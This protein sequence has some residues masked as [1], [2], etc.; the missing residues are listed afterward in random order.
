[1]W[2]C[3]C[4]EINIPIK[5]LLTTI[6][7]ID[8]G[9]KNG[10]TFC[11]R[12]PFIKNTHTHI[13][14]LNRRSVLKLSQNIVVDVGPKAK[15]KF[16]Y[17]VRFTVYNLTTMHAQP[18]R[19]PFFKKTHTKHESHFISVFSSS[20]KLSTSNGRHCIFQNAWIWNCVHRI[21]CKIH[22]AVST[23]TG[24]GRPCSPNRHT[25]AR[26]HHLIF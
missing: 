11:C 6:S 8:I 1:M 18:S 19:V 13:F 21:V 9:V 23:V 10:V 4:I 16:I 26:T 25:H 22:Q 17:N 20:S 2:Y 14:H 12:W 5:I 3:T 7:Q 15:Q 24:I